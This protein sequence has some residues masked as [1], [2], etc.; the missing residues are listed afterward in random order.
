MASSYKTD[1]NWL[2]PSN[3]VTVTNNSYTGGVN[4]EGLP[5][6][7]TITKKEGSGTYALYISEKYLTPSSQ[8]TTFGTSNSPAYSWN[9]SFNSNER[10]KISN[11]G[12]TD[13]YICYNSSYFKN[14][15]SGTLPWLYQKQTTLNLKAAAGGWAT[16]YNKD[17]AYVMPQGVKGYYVT[18]DESKANLRL[19]LAYDAGAAVPENTPLLLYGKVGT[20][21]SVIV[22]KKITP[23]EGTNYMA[24]ER[25]VDG[26]TSAGENMVYYKLTLDNNG[27]NLGFYYGADD[28]APFVM[29]NE[30]SAYLALPKEEAKQVRS[31]I[32]DPDTLTRL[33]PIEQQKTPEALYDLSGRRI[34]HPQRG[35]Y[36]QGGRVVYQK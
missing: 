5:Y 11:S 7:I 21:H 4:A 15:K 12:E 1:K 24:G 35:L 17:F 20:Y 3:T 25:D 14:Y 34:Q 13:R 26:Y 16:F 31:L 28:G 22:N 23:F 9:I 18:L 29:K 32:L 10:I 8:A 27:N 36:I 33:S 30:T 19:T 6:E 2:N